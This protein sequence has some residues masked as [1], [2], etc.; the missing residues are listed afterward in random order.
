MLITRVGL[1]D[2]AV[3]VSGVD[4][5]T[6]LGVFLHKVCAWLTVAASPTEVGV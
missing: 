2:L 1:A 3:W 6:A 4:T 5:F